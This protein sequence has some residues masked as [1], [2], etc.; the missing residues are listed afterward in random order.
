MKKNIATGLL[1][2]A[3]AV[4]TMNAPA[5]ASNIGISS[6]GTLIPW[7]GF[8]NLVLTQSGSS[9]LL[10]PPSGATTSQF[11]VAAGAGFWK[12]NGLC[13]GVVNGNPSSGQV[14][15][16]TCSNLKPYQAWEYENGQ[17]RPFPGGSETGFCL[18][19]QGGMPNQ[20]AKIG[21]A[22]C[23]GTSQS[24]LFWPSGM[25]VNLVNRQTYTPPSSSV[26]PVVVDTGSNFD[27]NG[28]SDPGGIQLQPWTHNRASS[29]RLG[30][31]WW[32]SGNL[33]R[34]AGITDVV[35]LDVQGGTLSNGAGQLFLNTSGTCTGAN[36]S[37]PHD[38]QVFYMEPSSKY[39]DGASV[40]IHNG[41]EFFGTTPSCMDIRF[42]N[43]SP[44]NTVELAQC[45]STDAQEWIIHM[46]AAY[47]HE[48]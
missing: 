33:I 42:D 19:I 6:H 43:T 21:L 9:V 18:D 25:T 26:P 23:N 7:G 34:W 48:E 1:A 39:H 38:G 14:D 8:S 11:T 4:L 15:L 44:G 41:L 27:G 30:E 36:G 2:A 24:Q 22:P 5:K 31:Y 28:Y 10:E 29:D 45:N 13:L 17:I 46:D 37:T 20:G 16:E 35:C 3:S 12:V 32:F 47:N 40:T